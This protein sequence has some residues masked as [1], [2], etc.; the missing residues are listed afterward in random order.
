MTL[1]MR[2]RAYLPVLRTLLFIEAEHVGYP[3]LLIL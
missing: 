1:A 3:E 2:T